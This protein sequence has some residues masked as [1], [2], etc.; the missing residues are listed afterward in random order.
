MLAVPL[1]DHVPVLE[2]V[3]QSRWMM[4]LMSGGFASLIN[5]SQFFIVNS[6]GP[7]TS[8]VVGHLKTISIVSIGWVVSGRGVGDKSALG[9]V[10]TVAGI[11][12]YSSIM[13]KNR[14]N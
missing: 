5:I 4:I 6:S 12:G 1:V 14:K 7:V 13:L 9:V 8:T 11:I 10:M 2:N 3:P